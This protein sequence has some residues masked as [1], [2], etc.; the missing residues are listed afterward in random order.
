LNK[1]FKLPENLFRLTKKLGKGAYGK[2]M[3]ATHIPSGKPFAVKR[4][5]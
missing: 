4:F 2:V 5:E 3:Q 1:D